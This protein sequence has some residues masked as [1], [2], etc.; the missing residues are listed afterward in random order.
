VKSESGGKVMV[1]E[2]PHP[3]LRDTLSRERRAMGGGPSPAPAGEG[4]RRP[5]EGEGLQP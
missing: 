3:S 2:N 5:G 1:A 4:G